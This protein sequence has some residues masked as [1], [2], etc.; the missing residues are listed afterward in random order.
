MGDSVEIPTE[1]MPVGKAAKPGSDDTVLLPKVAPIDPRS[2]DTIPNERSALD[3]SS[4]KRIAHFEL[5]RELA[6]GG[7]G[8][9]FLARDTKLGR[10]VAIKFLLYNDPDYVQRFLI[11]ARATAACVHENIVTI[12]EVD[13]H[14]GLPYLV[15][16]YLEGKTLSE[17]LDRRKPSYRQR[18]ELLVPVVRAR[19]R[20][21]DHGIVHRDLKPS[22]IFITDRGQVKVLDFGV[23]RITAEPDPAHSGVM[24][25]RSE[26][27]SQLTSNSLVGTFPY[28][29]PEQFGAGE[30]DHLSDLWAVGILFWKMLIN[31]HP[32]GF[33]AS[34]KLRVRLNDLDTPLPSIG[35]SDLD[36]PP[37]LV[38]IVDKCLAMRKAER[39][40]GAT[41]LL[42]DLGA[43]LAPK[44]EAAGDVC[45]Y[46]GLASFGEDDAKYF[47]GR[48]NEIRTALA[49]LTTWPLL[50]VVGPSGVGKSSFVHAGLA[51]ALRATGAS[52]RVAALRPGRLPLHHLASVLEETAAT[53]E[54]QIDVLAKLRDAP[55]IFGM[56]L[57]D[58]ARRR[59]Q[60]LLVAVDQLEE[61]FTLCDSDEIRHVFL[62]ALLAAADDTSSPVRVVLSMRADFLDRLAVHKQ[63]LDELSRGLFFL[64]APDRE[65]LHQALVRPAELA[66]YT[67]ESPAIVD[68]ML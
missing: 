68:D 13:E 43:F 49:Q 30:V 14:E 5:I 12:F 4:N 3:F 2:G 53:G 22:N 34:E 24:V 21:H 27:A 52:W 51:P 55:G 40:Q 66:G 33:T 62:A 16:E 1:S 8:Q 50:A 37:E 44:T 18:C 54:V 63:F 20:A 19:E 60:K 35:R 9:V 56:M 45:P 10:K 47:F 26:E 36:M 58:A 6:R 17:L 57:R 7:M 46:R 67:F 48:E 39:Y 65:N 61:L 28:M 29:S 32:A 41:A 15:L 42:A 64:S 25:P 59:N 31:A 11:E 23:A 38:A